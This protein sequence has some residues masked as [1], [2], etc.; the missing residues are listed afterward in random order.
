MEASAIIG[1]APP[2]GYEDAVFRACLVPGTPFDRLSPF[3]I[4]PEQ[5]ALARAL[6]LPLATAAGLLRLAEEAFAR[7]ATLHEGGLAHGDAEL[8]NFIV[9][10]SP[11][12]IVPIDF[13]AAASR[14]G[15]NSETWD[16]MCAA[17]FGPLLRE[18]VFLQC[19]L[20]AQPGTFATLARQSIDRAFTEPDRF[21]REIDRHA[22]EPNRK[23]P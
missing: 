16:R 9:C 18:S 11:L 13:E 10:P 4:E 14:Q 20:G 7:L 8:H 1:I 3:G 17:D 22:P 15:A 12:E 21:R 19:R 5:M 2:M 6:A 23:T